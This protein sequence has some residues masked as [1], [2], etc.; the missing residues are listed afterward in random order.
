MIQRCSSCGSVAADGINYEVKT[1]TESQVIDRKSTG[2][3][4]KPKI[5]VPKSGKP[6]TSKPKAEKCMSKGT[7]PGKNRKPLTG[8]NTPK[9]QVGKNQRARKEAARKL[10]KCYRRSG[11]LT[12]A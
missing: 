4:K 1:E 11:P 12:H 6:K 10:K 8:C 2:N 3:P 7:K 5:T 9:N